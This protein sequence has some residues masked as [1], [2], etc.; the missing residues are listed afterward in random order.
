MKSGRGFGCGLWWGRGLR[1]HSRIEGRPWGV[2]VGGAWLR[3]MGAW[4]EVGAWLVVGAWLGAWLKSPQQYRGEDFGGWWWWGDG[5]VCGFWG[6][7][8]RVQGAC[9]R[10]GACPPD[11]PPPFPL[12]RWA[13]QAL[14]LGAWGAL[15]LRALGAAAL[16]L[17][18]LRLLVPLLPPP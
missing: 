4:L 18:A 11:A 6:G 3:Y 8:W 14:G 16:G 12:S 2:V 13:G 15:G 9:L 7:A 17:G 10:L 5:G 1:A